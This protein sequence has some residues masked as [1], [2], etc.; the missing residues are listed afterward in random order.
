MCVEALT[1]LALESENSMNGQEV[2]IL[3][4]LRVLLQPCEYLSRYETSRNA[5]VLLTRLNSKK[6]SGT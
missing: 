1:S 4:G 3:C 6:M 5:P 2:L